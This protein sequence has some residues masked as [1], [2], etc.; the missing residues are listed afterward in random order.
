MKYTNGE[1]RQILKEA[2]YDRK[3]QIVLLLDE[4]GDITTYKLSD[5]LSFEIVSSGLLI[6]SSVGG[7]LIRALSEIDTILII[8]PK[9][10]YCTRIDL[11][12]E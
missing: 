9:S 1:L 7:S 10:T 8:N 5:Y 6:E 12:E 11:F 3:E 2:I 4:E